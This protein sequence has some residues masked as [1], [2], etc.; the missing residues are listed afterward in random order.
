MKKCK[1]CGREMIDVAKFCPKC[2]T[3]QVPEKEI[4]ANVETASKK[5]K[6][7][8]IL[9]IAITIFSVFSP[10]IVISGFRYIVL[11]LM[12]FSGLLSI[13]ILVS[14]GVA[15]YGI[16]RKKYELITIMS[17]GLMLY[18]IMIIGI[19]LRVVSQ[20]V[21]VFLDIVI[22]GFIFF[23]GIVIMGI[24]GVLCGLNYNSNESRGFISQWFYA[25]KKS[26]ILY[27]QS[28]SGLLVSAAL[29]ILLVMLTFTAEILRS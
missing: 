7:I 17:N 12:D 28:F 8:A 20:S 18:F 26:L 4:I 6:A 21:M 10:V 15:A 22:G 2:G 16:L 9:G 13:M 25:S 3:P 23:F 19:Y 1:N 11:T 14:C 24:G 5:S 29:G 27:M